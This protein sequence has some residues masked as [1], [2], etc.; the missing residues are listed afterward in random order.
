MKKI[1]LGT[2]L[3]FCLNSFAQTEA[4]TND[5]KKVIL[6]SDGTWA[7]ADCGE[8]IKVVTNGNGKQTISGKGFINSFSEIEKNKQKLLLLKASSGAV[9]VNFSPKTREA[10]CVN[11]NAVGDIEFT[12]G[13]KVTINHMGDLDCEGN[14]SY[15]LSKDF[16]TLKELEMFKSKKI[17]NITVEYTTTENGKIVKFTRKSSFTDEDGDKIM[18]TIQCLSNL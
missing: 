12:D 3:L 8:L 1:L 14:F 9:I 15:Y 2:A 5:G 16:D 11:K 17:K 4:T 10:V 7:F 18:K 6:N 13:S